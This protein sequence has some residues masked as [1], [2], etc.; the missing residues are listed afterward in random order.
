VKKY[1]KCVGPAAIRG[2]I[3]PLGTKISAEAVDGK[4]IY[5]GC[6]SWEE[7]PGPAPEEKEEPK[8]VFGRKSQ[9][10]KSSL[11]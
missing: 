4:C 6:K 1:Y 11:L 7:C 10:D 3:V 2:R 9:K 8:K 5:D